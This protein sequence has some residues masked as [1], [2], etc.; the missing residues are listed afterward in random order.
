MGLV[1]NAHKNL[2][3]T[4]QSQPTAFHNHDGSW[5]NTEGSV[6]QRR[7]RMV[8]LHVRAYGSEQKFLDFKYHLQQAAK[9]YHANKQILE[10]RRVSANFPFIT[11]YK[12]FCIGNPWDKG[13]LGGPNTVGKANS[14]CIVILRIG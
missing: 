3:L 2:I 5:N 11:G 9:S 1:L 14:R 10:D 8:G 6:G 4:T 13:G 12:E 7:A